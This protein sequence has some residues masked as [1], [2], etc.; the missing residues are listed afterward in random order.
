MSWQNGRKEYG[1]I[2][3]NQIWKKKDTGREMTIKCKGKNKG[4]GSWLVIYHSGGK[5]KSHTVD[6]RSIYCYYI[7]LN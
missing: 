4:H 5:N 7:K 6:E 3:A 1:K 2:K